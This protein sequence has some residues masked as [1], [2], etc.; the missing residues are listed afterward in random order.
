MNQKVPIPTKPF[1]SRDFAPEPTN[2]NSTTPNSIALN[3][4]RHNLE[5]LSRA[6]RGF[7]LSYLPP[8]TYL[9]RFRQ[10][11]EDPT[12]TIPFQ[13]VQKFPKSGNEGLY[14][15]TYRNKDGAIRIRDDLTGLRKLETDIH[16][17]IHTP[18]EYETRVLTRWILDAL[19]P[20]R[21][22]Y[23]TKPPEYKR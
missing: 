2:S 7:H 9:E 22:R 1:L 20:P 3:S 17:S 13:T 18:D 16:E 23:S 8:D 4:P 11:K 19:I 14:G 12:R 15:W 5:Y 10:A 21:E 6:S